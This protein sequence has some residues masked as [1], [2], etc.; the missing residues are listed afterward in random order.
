MADGA[1]PDPLRHVWIVNHH[2]LIPSKDGAAGRHLNMAKWFPNSGWTAS[3]IVASTI[4][5]TGAQA[6]KG[7]RLK[8]VTK[9]RGVPVLWVRASA[10]GRST[11]RRFVGMFVFTLV[12]ILPHTTKTLQKPDVVVGSTVHLLAAWVGLRLA[13]RHRVPFVYEVRDVWPAALVH[14]GKLSPNGLLARFMTQLS[15]KLANAAN[16]VIAPLPHLDRYLAENKIDPSKFLWV[17]NG[18]DMPRESE[19]EPANNSDFTF[20]YLGSHGNANALDGIIEAFD[21][22]CQEHPQKSYRLRLVGDGPLKPQLQTLAASLESREFIQ[23]ENRI[24]Q[25]QVTTT[26]REA[27]CLVANLHDSPVYEYGISPNKLFAYLHASRPIIFACSAPNNPIQEA[28][29]GIVVPG[30]DRRALARAMHDMSVAPAQKR[31]QMASHGYEYVHNNYAHDVL[32]TRFAGGLER[33]LEQ[34]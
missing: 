13:R 32:A 2:A 6:M 31:Y 21:Q 3:L 29:A 19:V 26:A 30:D 8:K 17:S 28:G 33:L 22:L 15:L 18:I 12:A 34:S 7:L 10:Y 27:D 20:M 23:F 14:L 5:A 16:L 25:D 24:P 4:H 9:E 1:S 11:A